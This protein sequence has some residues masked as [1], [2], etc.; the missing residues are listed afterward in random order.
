MPRRAVCAPRSLVSIWF[1]RPKESSMSGF[2]SRWFG[3]RAGGRRPLMARLSVEAL[4]ERV[5]PSHVVLPL[6]PPG[7]SGAPGIHVAAEAN[8]HAGGLQTVFTTKIDWSGP[9]AFEIKDFS[10]GVENPTTI[11]SATGGAGAGAR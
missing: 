1:R 9:G 7:T 10:F 8:P 5:L 6:A 2:L 4:G 11:G 3:S